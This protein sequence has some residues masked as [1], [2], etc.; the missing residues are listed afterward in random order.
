MKA[1][2]CAD[3]NWGIG[4]GNRLLVSIP[5]DMRFFRETTQGHVVVMGRKTLESFP[6]GRPLPHRTNI[7][8]T[9]DVTFRPAGATVVHS[10]AELAEAL[11]PYDPGD[12]FVIGGAEV[13][14]L[15]LAQ[16]DTVYVTRV[17]YAYQAD[18]FFP[19]LDED[20]AWEKTEESEEQ[21]YFDAEYTFCTYRRRAGQK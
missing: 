13:Y 21:T 2:L 19:N 17:D 14:R 10:T 12:I 1:I 15:L 4:F 6:G 20:P 3:R 7:V 8:L 5:A 11:R 18:R 9:H 16:C